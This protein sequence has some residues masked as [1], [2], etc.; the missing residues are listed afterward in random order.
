MTTAHHKE[1][2]GLSPR[3]NL[4]DHKTRM[5][6]ILSS[7]AEETATGLHQKNDS[8]GYDEIER[9][10]REAG[11][12]AADA[13]RAVEQRLGEPVV[14]SQNFLVSRRKRV[15]QLSKRKKPVTSQIEEKGQ[16]PEAQQTLFDD[17]SE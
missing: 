4:A 3:H 17:L 16:Q 6:L 11:D 15:S 2:K 1:L 13:R 7:L 5:E 10:V 12:T 9:D 14:S 8:Q